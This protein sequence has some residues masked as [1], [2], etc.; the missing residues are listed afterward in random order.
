VYG[1]MVSPVVIATSQNA[2][3]TTISISVSFTAAGPGALFAVGNINYSAINGSSNAS[4]LYIN[5]NQVASD[6]T[7]LTRA[8]VGGLYTGGGGCS[9][10]YVA[11][12]S[13]QF[14]AWLTLLYVPLI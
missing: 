4:T 10:T 11:A 14:T 12:S 13:P 3:N 5:G 1:Q 9:A 7:Q 2:T 8:H 6:T